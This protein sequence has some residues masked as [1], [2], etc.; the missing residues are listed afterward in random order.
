MTSFLSKTAIAP[1]IQSTLTER[2]YVVISRQFM[3][4]LEAL[5]A[6]HDTELRLE[7]LPY[8]DSEPEHWERY[9]HAWRQLVRLVGMEYHEGME[10]TPVLEKAV[11]MLQGERTA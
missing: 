4:E 2:V 5:F 7:D 9:E 1:C 6:E 11:A 10:M 8:P 3:H